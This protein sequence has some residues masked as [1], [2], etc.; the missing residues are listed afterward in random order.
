MK[1]IISFVL[2]L[3]LLFIGMSFSYAEEIYESKGYKYKVLEDGTIAILEIPFVSGFSKA[4]KKLPAT[5]DGFK[6]STIAG[7]ALW[8]EHIEKLIIPEGVTTLAGAVDCRALIELSL[9][10]TLVNIGEL[11][12]DYYPFQ[13]CGNLQKIT[14]SKKNPVYAVENNCVY[15]RETKELLYYPIAAKAKKVSTPKGIEKIASY[16]FY[17]TQY[18]ETLVIS[19]GV[20]S[21]G[22]YAIMECEKLKQ[23]DIPAT[24]DI[25][26]EWKIRDCNELV[27]LTVKKDNPY[28]QV[29]NNALINTIHNRLLLLPAKANNKDYTIPDTIIEIGNHA[30]YNCNNLKA[31]HI[32][33]N[34]EFIS[35]HAIEDCRFLDTLTIEEGVL[36]AYN[37]SILRCPHLINISYPDSTTLNAIPPVK[38]MNR[39][40]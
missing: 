6:V 19:E 5:I 40:E 36:Y 18:L 15:N 7:R 21:M 26:D 2:A 38:Y 33:G 37:E 22:D 32:P 1:K 3:L 8:A 29:I 17:K 30:I 13:G 28:N 31:L 11:S 34:V 25:S 4:T 24:L 35:K 39:E 27:K 9:P 23:I 14:I 20:S 10:S 16:A 12:S